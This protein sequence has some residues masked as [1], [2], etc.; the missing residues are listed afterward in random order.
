[1]VGSEHVC[2]CQHSRTKRI[3]SSTTTS[4]RGLRRHA[5]PSPIPKRSRVFTRSYDVGEVT[6]RHPQEGHDTRMHRCRWCRSTRL[7]PEKTS[8]PYHRPVDRSM[9]S[10]LTSITCSGCCHCR[11]TTNIRIPRRPFFT[12][13]MV[14][15]KEPPP[16]QRNAARRRA[17]CRW[18][19]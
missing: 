11:S 1:M 12:I 15:E 17:I 14:E 3:R 2:R 13:H 7:L 6:Q 9:P 10:T 16:P 19:D 18:E 4:P 8:A 5:P